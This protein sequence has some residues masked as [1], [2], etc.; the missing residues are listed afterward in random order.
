MI[1]SVFVDFLKF[2]GSE[3]SIFV[4][5]LKFYYVTSYNVTYA[6]L[7]RYNALSLTHVVA[8][9]DQFD[10]GLALA[11]SLTHGV[12]QPWCRSLMLSL[13]RAVAH[14][15]CLSLGPVWPSFSFN[16]VA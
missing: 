4:D 14:P 5:I 13:N 7:C 16:G 2:D 9:S 11:L 8:H 1:Q 15:W 12:A 6:T 3:Y 10:L